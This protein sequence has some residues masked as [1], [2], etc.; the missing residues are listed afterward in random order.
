VYI[1]LT[2]VLFLFPPDLPTT[3][4]NMSTFPLSLL[5]A[6][7]FLI[8]FP[9]YCVAALGIVLLI[10]L[11]QWIVDGRKNFTGPRHGLEE[12]THGVMPG[13]A[14]LEEQESGEEIRE[15]I[16]AESGSL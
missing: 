14:A 8:W 11:F 12:L 6:D 10:S 5:F 15:K 4:S 3:A 1:I 16:A 2:T 9:D 7:M 13:Q